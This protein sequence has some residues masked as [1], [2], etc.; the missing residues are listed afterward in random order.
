MPFRWV[1]TPTQGVITLASSGPV[2]TAI[3]PGAFSAALLSIFLMR[4]WAKG[5][6]R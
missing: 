6:R 1:S 4:A 3:T 5:E 2:T